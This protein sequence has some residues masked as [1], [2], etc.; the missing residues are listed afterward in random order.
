MNFELKLRD[1]EKL[2]NSHY[3][4]EIQ[5]YKDK[6][7]HFRKDKAKLKTEIEELQK[8][9]FFL[10]MQ[11]VGKVL[12]QY[13]KD[14]EEGGGSPLDASASP[15]DKRAAEKLKQ[16]KAFKFEREDVAN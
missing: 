4:K 16:R 9:K 6:E 5:G 2:V 7:E 15:S 3:A 13:R 14:E 10:R 8:Q 12:V 11:G 1:L